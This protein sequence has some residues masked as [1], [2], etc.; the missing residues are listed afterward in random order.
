MKPAVWVRLM[1]VV[2]ACG[3]GAP[4]AVA[5]ESREWFQGNHFTL[6]T[7][8]PH[9][10]FQASWTFEIARNGD[11]FLRKSETTDGISATGDIIML[12][13]GVMLVRNLALQEHWELKALDGPALAMQLAVKVLNL[14]FPGGSETVSA[15]SDIHLDEAERGIFLST[16]SSDGHVLAPW[17]AQGWAARHADGEVNFDL[18]VRA[19]RNREGAGQHVIPL[20]GSWKHDPVPLALDDAMPLSDWRLY[21]IAPLAEPFG[22]GRATTPGQFARDVGFAKLGEVRAALITIQKTDQTRN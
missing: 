6:Q 14:A 20:K 9:K 15:H 12:S 10:K 17:T 19:R 5:G 22:P 21:V 16:P 1:I 4:R 3:L 11:L 2:L 18:T 7:E 8:D 13:S